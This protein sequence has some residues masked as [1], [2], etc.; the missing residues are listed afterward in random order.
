MGDFKP[1]A[2][3]YVDAAEVMALSI[4]LPIACFAVVIL[5]FYTRSSQKMGIGIDDWLSVLGLVILPPRP[6]TD[7]STEPRCS[8]L[9]PVVGV[10]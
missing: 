7:E 10:A 6:P 3:R 5:R 9:S 4:A 8:S 1:F 2:F